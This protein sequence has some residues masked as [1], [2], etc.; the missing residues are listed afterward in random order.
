MNYTKQKIPYCDGI[1]VLEKPNGFDAIIQTKSLKAILHL[2][3]SFFTITY[4][5][6]NRQAS[7]EPCRFLVELGRIELPSENKFTG[8]SPGAGYV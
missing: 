8:V 2:T 4:Y 5:F 1:F 6:K 3:S 7:Y